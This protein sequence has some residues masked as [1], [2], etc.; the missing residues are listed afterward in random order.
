[1]RVQWLTAICGVALMMGCGGNGKTTD[2]TSTDNQATDTSTADDSSPMTTGDSS[3]ITTGDSSPTD[4][5][6]NTE[7]VVRVPFDP[8]KTDH[9]PRK[10]RGA[11]AKMIL[12]PLDGYWTARGAARKIQIMSQAR[13]E[14]AL[15]GPFKDAQDYINRVFKPVQMK[16]P[17]LRPG[18]RFVFDQKTDQLMIEGP[19]RN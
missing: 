7:N 6:T 19:R 4:N 8:G 9:V 15:N 11:I 3:P 13:T 12:Y 2:S 14:K 10:D 16:P 1:M 18:E 5:S 17:E